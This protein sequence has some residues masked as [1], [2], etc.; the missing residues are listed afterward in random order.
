[1]SVFVD[2][3]VIIYSASPSPVRP[4]AIAILD[5]IGHGTIAGRTSTAVLEEVW[6]IESRGREEGLAGVTRRAY[7]AF[8]PLLPVTDEVFRLALDLTN[9]RMGTNDRIH[10]ATCLE[11]GIATIVTADDDFDGVPG[12]RRVDPLAP[13]ALGRLRAAP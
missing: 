3:N 9:L 7:A 2:A 4:P 12:L 1:V 13:G 6:H 8:A 10:V 11:H 5:A